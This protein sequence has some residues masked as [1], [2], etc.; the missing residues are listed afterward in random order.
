MR[1][2]LVALALPAMLLPAACA[3][4]PATYGEVVR[5]GYNPVEFGYAAGRR[6]LL[7]EFRGDPFGL[8]DAAFEDRMVALLARH[9]PK[10]QPTNYTTDPGPDARTDYRVVF[11]FDP[12]VSF[13][14][15]QLCRDGGALPAGAGGAAPLEAAA[16]FCR[17]GGALTSVRG[18]L[19]TA[20]GVEDKRFEALIGQMVDAL[21]PR[22]DPNDDDDVPFLLLTGR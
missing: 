2:L 14:P 7:T 6:D 4:Q 13:L 22:D 20:Y 9:Q 18:R 3:D 19:D 12:P 16:A 8:G 11:V 15:N 1:N 5:G 21:F 17:G 10:Q